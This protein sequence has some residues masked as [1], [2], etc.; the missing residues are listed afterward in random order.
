MN[1]QPKMDAALKVARC[2]TKL[3]IHHPFFGAVA[4]RLDIKDSVDVPTMATNGLSIMWN[5]EFV[6]SITEAHTMGV[7]VH[8]IYHVIL[9]HHLRRGDRNPQGWNV[10]ADLCINPMVLDGGFTLPEGALFDAKYDGKWTT[11]RVY[12]DFPEAPPTACAWGGVDDQPGAGGDQLSDAERALA[13]IEVDE[14]VQA[15]ADMARKAG[16][17]PGNI[18]EIVKEMAESQIDWQDKFQRFAGGTQPEDYSRRRY[19]KR[20]YAAFGAISP[21]V[22]KVG[23]G[24]IAV[25]WDISGSV[26]SNE[27]KHFKGELNAFIEDCQPDSVTVI[28][29]DTA[30]KS[31]EYL[32]QGEL[33]EDVVIRGRGGT[34]VEPVFDYIEEQGLD[35]ERMVYLTDM[36]F[37][38]DPKNEPHYPVMWLS[39]RPGQTAPFGELCYVKV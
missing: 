27:F 19:S 34:R 5:R 26:S 4:F 7:L 32:T 37:Y 14:M 16:K 25:G 9:K 12:A 13:E 10:A 18:E 31:V 17:L 29:C 21:S 20:I 36:G 3:A 33:L 24:H 8:E 23:V 15:A 38:C 39:T 30:V 2:I 6:D 22:E 1:A 11:E 28:F 35:I